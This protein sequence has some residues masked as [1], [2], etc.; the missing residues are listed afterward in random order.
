MDQVINGLASEEIQ[1][2][3]LSHPDGDTMQLDT[4][5]TF[6]EGKESGQASQG[7]LAGDGVNSGNA[8]NTEKQCGFCGGKHKPGRKFCHAAKP[9]T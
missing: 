3:V 1:R 4:L 2:D 6:V 9:K 5:L 8:V 7:L